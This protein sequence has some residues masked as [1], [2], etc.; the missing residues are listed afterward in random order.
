M[1]SRCSDRAD[2]DRSG[3]HAS[4]SVAPRHAAR[5]KALM[6]ERK[7]IEAEAEEFADWFPLLQVLTSMPGAG[8]R[9]ASQIFLAAGDFSAFKTAGHLAVYA[10]IALV[11]RRSGRAIRGKFS[12]RAGN[13]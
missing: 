1:P 9:T 6:T 12:S 5:I 4:E 11:T 2:G 13:K 8:V 10:G 3:G 7:E